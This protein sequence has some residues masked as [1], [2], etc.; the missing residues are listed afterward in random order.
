MTR[1]LTRH[2]ALTLAAGLAGTVLAAGAAQAQIRTESVVYEVDG[3]PYEGFLAVNEGFAEDRPLVLVIHDWDG[4]GDYEERRATMLAELGFA[5][6]AVDLYGEGVRPTTT[7]ES[8]AQ[9]GAL[10]ADREAM[11]ARLMAG[12]ETASAQAGVN[13]DAAAVIGYCFGGAAVLEFAR[14]GA[15]LDAFVSFHGGLQAPEGAT[16]D[17]MQGDLLVLHGSADPVSGMEDIATLAATLNDAAIDYRME[18]YGGARHSFT[19]WGSGDYDPQADLQSW[20]EMLTFLD[21]RLR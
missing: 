15:D 16:W 2:T 20:N 12:L 21:E 6:F 10:Y 14:A 8:R 19:V 7:E 11:R 4:L 1:I 9:S 17:A 3:Q 18:I 5:A 13:A